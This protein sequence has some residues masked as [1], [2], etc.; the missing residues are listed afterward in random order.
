MTLVELFAGTAALAL[1]TWGAKPPASRIGS[2][3]GYVK[4]LE[5]ELGIRSK[6]H[7]VLVEKDPAVANAMRC[8]IQEG[9]ELAAMVASLAGGDPRMAWQHAK[10]NKAADGLYGAAC[11]WLW[12]CGARGGIGGFK[13]AHVHRSSVDGFIPS[14][15]SLIR[16]IK[17]FPAISA[18]VHCADAFEFPVPRDAVVYLDPPYEDAISYAATVGGSVADLAVKL[19]EAGH[20][21]GVS[22]RYPLDLPGS[23]H[24]DL[25]DLRKG[26]SRRSMT[27]TTTE[28]LTVVGPRPYGKEGH[29]RERA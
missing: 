2:K 10:A 8:L 28:W 7:V 6:P 18:E 29:L 22:E 4:S 26:Q 27:T 21:V 15:D 5:Q 19:A 14:R 24:V 20:L 23:R 1:H 13:G 16:R 17:A 11:W 25:T 9:A 12:T 3:S